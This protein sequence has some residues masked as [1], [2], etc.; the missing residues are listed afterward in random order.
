MIVPAGCI[1]DRLGNPAN[2]VGGKLPADIINPLFAFSLNRKLRY[3]YD[4]EYFRFKDKNGEA[5]YPST[6]PDMS[7][8]VELLK[9]Y[10]QKEKFGYNKEDAVV[11]TGQ[12]P[13]LKFEDGF[14]KAVFSGAESLSVALS[15]H[16]ADE[17]YIGFVGKG[18]YPRPALGLWREE[19]NSITVEPSTEAVG[20]FTVNRN[21]GAMRPAEASNCYGCFYGYDASQNNQRVMSVNQSG[22]NVKSET[23]DNLQNIAIGRMR[24]RYYIGE[25]LEVVMH[26]EDLKQK[27]GDLSTL[28]TMEFYGNYT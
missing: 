8:D 21:R 11:V 3:L 4:G 10:D 18:D 26:L 27:W 23:I 22:H 6:T 14:Y 15:Q 13:K 24:D 17:F 16:V 25:V 12:P 1:L 7:E 9:I 5:D 20:K 2:D 19:E 28:N